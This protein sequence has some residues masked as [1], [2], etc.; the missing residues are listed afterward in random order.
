VWPLLAAWAALAPPAAPE[1]P[2]ASSVT[3]HFEIWSGE[4]GAAARALG[5]HLEAAR[6]VILADMGLTDPGGPRLRVIAAASPA[7]LGLSV[8]ALYFRDGSGETVLVGRGGAQ[9]LPAATHEMVHA[10]LARVGW[11]PPLWLNEGLADYYATMRFENGR[12][13]LGRPAP[14][15]A[16]RL[17]RQSWLDLDA[18]LHRWLDSGRD[19]EGRPALEAYRAAWALTAHLARERPERFPALIRR[20]ASGASLE[21]AFGAPVSKIEQGLRRQ[22][23]T[24]TWPERRGSAIAPIEASATAPVAAWRAESAVLEIGLRLRAGPRPNAA[25]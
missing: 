15:R 22:I 14:A 17:R 23:E 13:W 21:A 24:E 19:L 16:A 5:D 9:A 4:S 12:A 7:R 3:S 18:L 10:L 8:D 20:V 25:P 6:A 11:N 2:W 1:P